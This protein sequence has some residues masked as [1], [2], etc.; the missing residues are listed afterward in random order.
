[1]NSSKIIQNLLRKFKVMLKQDVYHAI[2][3][4]SCSIY[5]TH[6]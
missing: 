5:I 1:M 4:D 6:L 2:E 3:N